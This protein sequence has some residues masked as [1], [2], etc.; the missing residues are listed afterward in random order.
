MEMNTRLQ[1]EHPVTELV[2]GLDLVDLA[3]A[4]RRR[5]AAAAAQEPMCSFDGHA[6]EARLY[7]EK[8]RRRLPARRPARA[9]FARS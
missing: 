3:V 6:I 2:T 1:V 7:A 5:R 9:A 4:R 8:T